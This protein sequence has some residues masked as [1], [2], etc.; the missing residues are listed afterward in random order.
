MNA[1]HACQ[2]L[3]RVAC[4]LVALLSLESAIAQSIPGYPESV[5]SYDAREVAMLPRFCTHAQAFRG[6]VPGGMNQVEID[7]WRSVF[8]DTYEHM[9][10]YCW[11]LM[12]T[13]R[14]VVLARDQQVRQAYLSDSLREFNYVIERAPKDFIL[15]PEILAKKGENLI[16][17]GQGPRGVLE[18]ER[19]AELKPDYWPPY[20]YMSD[21]FKGVGDPVKARQLLERGLTHAPDAIGLKRR[22]A[23]LGPKNKP[24]G[25]AR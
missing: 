6:N 8:G 5:E 13:N 10:H 14:A 24:A 23:E 2:S 17:L 7:K 15:L 25:S 22:L 18:L 19:A 9:H 11:G 16:R 3:G 1:R 20:A 4:L 12:K 21:Y